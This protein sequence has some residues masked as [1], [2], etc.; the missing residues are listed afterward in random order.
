M[1]FLRRELSP[2]SDRIILLTPQL[3]RI[4]VWQIGMY[5]LY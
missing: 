1:L 3:H 2:E 4:Q 5:K